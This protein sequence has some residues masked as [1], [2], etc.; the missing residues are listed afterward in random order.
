M[1][2]V[3]TSYSIHYTKL[4]DGFVV[5][6]DEKEQ[7]MVRSIIGGR[8]SQSGSIIIPSEFDE[9]TKIHLMR[10]DPDLITSSFGTL[11]EEL[12][13]RLVITSYSIHYTKLY[14]I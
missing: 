7:T 1:W 13:V 5:S 10:R 8:D 9:G 4:Y 3:I 6:K 11:G 14:E 2:T 12:K